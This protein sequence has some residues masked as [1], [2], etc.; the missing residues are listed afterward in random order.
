VDRIGL[1]RPVSE[2]WIG[3]APGKTGLDSNNVRPG[4]IDPNNFGIYRFSTPGGDGPNLVAHV[5]TEGLFSPGGFSLN[6]ADLAPA[7]QAFTPNP[8]PISATEA[9]LG[10]GEFYRLDS[11]SI[12]PNISLI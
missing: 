12:A 4:V 5:Q 6:T 11:S 1:N 9:Y 10:W 3:R 8:G 7:N 2:F